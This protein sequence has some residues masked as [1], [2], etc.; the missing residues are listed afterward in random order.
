MTT[1]WTL[2]KDSVSTAATV[3]TIMQFL[4][5]TAIC[6]EFIRKGH[7]GE[8]SSLPLVVGA[9]NGLNWLR[10]G[11]LIEDNALVLVN[12]VGAVLYSLYTTCFYVYTSRKLAIQV[13]VVSA[14]SLF[15]TILVYIRMVDHDYAVNTMGVVAVGVTICNFASPLANLGNVIRT[16]STETL[17]FPLIMANFML[18]GL[19]WLYGSMIDDTFVQIPNAM[20]MILSTVQLL[21]FCIFP[22]TTDYTST[23]ARPKERRGSNASLLP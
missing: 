16:R 6:R 2:D 22:A 17:P 1:D 15:G 11:L 5:G 20:G 9:L 13:Q 3:V 23:G 7:T 19:W 14:A 18:T 4:T 10:Y 21:L 8:V 12:F